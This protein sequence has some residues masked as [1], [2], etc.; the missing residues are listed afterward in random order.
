M[1]FEEILETCRKNTH[2]KSWDEF[3]WMLGIS[4]EGLRLIRK[5]KGALKP[6]TLEALM[7]GSGLEAPL[8]VATWEAEHGKV[9]HVRESWERLANTWT[10]N[11]EEKGKDSRELDKLSIMLSQESDWP[12]GFRE[13]FQAPRPV[14]KQSPVLEFSPMGIRTGV[15]WT[16]PEEK[17]APGTP[18]HGPERRRNHRGPWTGPE[19]RTA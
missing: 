15:T 11:E 12:N 13:E 17:T 14:L 7:R 16:R 8:I 1:K 9:P 19:R 6:K 3:A 2:A 4:T 10:Q 18:W 5:G